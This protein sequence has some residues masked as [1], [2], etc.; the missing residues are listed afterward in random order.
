MT[1][2]VPNF[3]FGPEQVDVPTEFRLSDHAILAG[4][5]ICSAARD[6]E[7]TPTT[8]LRRGLVLGKITASGKYAQYSD[9]ATDGT[10]VAAGILVHEVDLLGSYTSAHDATGL[11]L[12]HGYVNESALIGIDANGKADLKHVIF[13]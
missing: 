13:G 12:V 11:M 10:G 2:K 9:A 8:T 1:E 7:N 3:G 6:G 4:I 5:T